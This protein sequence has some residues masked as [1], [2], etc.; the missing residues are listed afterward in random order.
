MPSGTSGLSDEWW[1][2]AVIYQIY[3][4]SF[5]DSNGDGIG[6]LAGVTGKLDHV[7]SL[8]VDAIWLSPFFTSPMNDFGYDISDYRCVD[9]MFGSVGDFQ[10]LLDRAHALGLKVLIDQVLS[11]SSDQHDWFKQSRIDRENPKADWY[12]WAD[13]KPDGSPP[14]NWLSVFGGVA[15]T[16]EAR[17][18]QYYLHNFLTSQPDLNFHNADVRAA[19]LDNMRF[20]LDMGVDGF[21]L[22]VINY[23]FHHRDLP[24]NPAAD[25]SAGGAAVSASNPYGWQEH[26][27]DV[28]Q[29][30]NLDFLRELRALLDEYPG[31][32]TVGEI[33]SSDPLGDM[34]RYT[35]GGDKLHMAYTFDLLRGR[36]D[37]DY[38]RG[39]LTTVNQSLG[40]GWP[41][42]S[43][44]NHDVIRVCS[45]WGRKHPPEQFAPVVLALLLSL[46]GSVCL[47]Q[48][49]ELGLVEADVPF[50]RLQDPFGKA[51]WPDFKGRDGCRTPMVWADTRG[52]GFSTNDIVEPWL[53]IDA[54]HLPASV[55]SQEAVEG[56]VLNQLRRF[57]AWR[58]AQP[59]LRVGELE[60]VE[61]T[62]D[63]LAIVRR[64]DDQALFA[65][66]NL[67]D[68]TASIELS[69]LGLSEPLVEVGSEFGFSGRIAEGTVTLDPCQAVYAELGTP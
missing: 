54:R 9:P 61:G 14:N 7:A 10:R 57:I 41:C 62:K 6:D 48:G 37:A 38:L 68:A 49:D 53:P 60:V 23:C 64:S 29:P 25:R 35:S 32:T 50:E 40:D 22:D 58:S 21:R 16:W 30:E 67:S 44:S 24:D 11:H 27:F 47:Y 45:R 52:A 26:R 31:R 36:S 17:R 59:A 66:F 2:G 63:I 8:G 65:A 43:L 55:A 15:W 39:V 20:W 5:C 19:Q 4:R 13:P 3:P 33:G 46:R 28:S 51:F 18:Q 1:R 69:T 56:S 42:W 12:V 34:A